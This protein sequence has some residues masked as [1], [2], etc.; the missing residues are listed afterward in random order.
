MRDLGPA[1]FSVTVAGRPRR[2]VTAEFVD[3]GASGTM[4]ASAPDADAISTNEG[5]G[6][7]LGRMVMFV[8][9]QNTLD[10]GSARQVARSATRFFSGLT[11]ADRS[12]LAL[13]PVGQGVAFTWAHA[14]VR[15]A[16]QRV[17]G[18]AAGRTTW[19]YGSLAD[20]RDIANQQQMALRN[21]GQ[22]E[23]GGSILAGGRRRRRRRRWR[24]RTDAG[25]GSRSGTGSRRIQRR[26]VGR[27]R[28]RQHWQWRTDRRRARGLELV[29]LRRLWCEQL[30]AQP[31]DAGRIR[32]A[33]DANQLAHERVGHAAD[34]GTARQ[35][36]R[37]QDSD[38]DF[39]R[40]A[41]GR[42]RRNVPDIR[43]GG[44]G[45]RGACDDLH[46]LRA[47]LHFFRR[48]T[49]HRP[50]GVAR[51]IYPCRSA[52]NAGRHDRWRNVP[53]RGWRRWGL[54]PPAPRAWRVLQDRHRK[55][56]ERRRC[57]E[58]A[59]ESAGGA[60]WPHDPGPRPVRRAHVRGPRLGGAD[61]VGARFPCAGLERRPARDELRHLGSR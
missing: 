5:G 31:A 4:L 50:D 29:T 23:C 20:A 9:D 51:P 52:R 39:R 28:D 36:A 61:V 13:L 34:A 19:E 16:L 15:D 43:G 46:D 37:R 3:A 59:D 57:Q 2:V 7:G 41:A 30:H 1:D 60:K 26:R 58:Q 25:G 49:R 10:I 6:G 55:G 8:V 21:L 56:S 42:T 24:V 35:R 47:D 33:H 18:T 40:V 53:S 12:G 11:F 27:Y 45:A 14:T 17:V 32:L 48:S 44:G 22:R 54:R 38:S